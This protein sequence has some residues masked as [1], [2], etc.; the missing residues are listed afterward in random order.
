MAYEVT[1]DPPTPNVVKSDALWMRGKTGETLTTSRLGLNVRNE[2]GLNARAFVF[3]QNQYL[4][5]EFKSIEYLLA[6]TAGI[7]Y[8]LFDTEQTKLAADGAAGGVWE[9]NP[10]ADARGSGAVALGE[11][12]TQALTSTTVLTQS[13]SG[14]WK[15]EDFGDALLTAGIS[16]AASMS[17]RMQLKVELLDTFKNRPPVPGVEKNDVAVLMAIV[18]KM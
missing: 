17:A 7:G 18:Y 12:L 6:P 9:K 13:V 1:Y 3:G 2:Y 15:T 4:R 16:L 8:R 10:A 14:L 11:K 5:D